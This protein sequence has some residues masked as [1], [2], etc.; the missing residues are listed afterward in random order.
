MRPILAQ[1]D[2][3]AAI[4]HDAA[5]RPDQPIRQAAL[6]DCLVG[7]LAA[8]VGLASRTSFQTPGEQPP[9]LPLPAP[10]TSARAVADLLLAPDTQDT[11]QASLGMAAANA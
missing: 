6:G 8:R 10:G 1:S 3:L 2:L 5:A 4:H 9:P 11:D 7:L